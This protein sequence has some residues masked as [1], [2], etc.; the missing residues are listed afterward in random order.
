MPVWI[1]LLLTALYLAGLFWIAWRRDR[2]AAEPGF[3][4]S[5]IVY[6]LAI[7]VYCTSWTYFGAVGTA[8]SSGWDYLP[9]YIGPAIVFAFMPGLVRRIGDIVRREGVTSLSD[10]LSARYGKSQSVATLASLAAVT[11]S[12]PYIALQL[13]SV[14]MSF[15]ALSDSVPMDDSSRPADETVLLTALA[16][17]VFAIL[18]GA[19]QSDKTRQNAGL[20]RVLAFEAL[21]K[22]GALVAVCVLSIGILSGDTVTLTERARDVFEPGSLSARFITITLLSMGAIICLPRQ[23]HVTMIERRNSKD[24]D[25]ARWL[26]PAYMMATSLVV[27]PIALVG[28]S[29]LPASSPADLYVLNLPLSQGDGILALLVF[30]GGFSAAM[31]MVIVSTVAL[32]TMVTN[33]LIVP[34]LLKS[35]RFSS[36]AGDSGARLLIIR[37]AVILILLLLAY[38]Y[39]RTAGSS[40]ALAQIGLLSFAS[41]VQF[42]PALLGGI[43]WKD[44]KRAGAVA[45]LVLGMGAWA[46]TLFLPAL[47]G[48]GRMAAF[49]PEWLD[50]HALFGAGLGDSLTHGVVWSL[51]LNLAGYIIGS[52]RARERLRDRVQAAAFTGKSDKSV[53]LGRTTAIPASQVTPD[54]LRTL[55]ER[56]LDANAVQAAFEQFE[57]ETAEQVDFSAP[58][59]WRLVQRTER[60]LARALGSSSARVVMASAVGGM[61]VTLPDVLSILDS[62]TRAERF[63]R[64]ML[65]SMLENIQQGISVVDQDQRL[66]AWNSAYVDLFDYP[67]DLVQVGRPVADLITYNLDK[68]WIE[69]DPAEQARRRI[70]H[71]R[72]GR[73]HT[74]ER[75]NPDGR[76]L[77]I[78]GNPMPGGGYVTTFTDIT[79]DKRREQALVDANE[80]LEA[81]VRE[82]TSDLEAMAADLHVAREDAEGANASK[83]R[84]LAAASHDL[85]QPLNAARLFLG[86]LIADDS[87]KSD[88]AKLTIAKTDKAIQSADDLLKGLLDISRLDHGHVTAKPV[89]IALAPLL[90]DL[91]D[92][93]A[94]MA[95]KVGLEIRVAPTRLSVY[96]DPDYLTSILRNFISNARRYTQAG[97]VLVGARRRGNKAQIEVWD[98]GPGI[99]KS[100]QALLFEEF[101]RFDDTDN[102]GLRGAGLGLSVVRRLAAIMECDIKVRSEPGRGSVF[103]I[104]VPLAD[105]QPARPAPSPALTRPVAHDLSALRILCVDDEASIRDG[106]ATLLSRWGCTVQTVAKYNDALDAARPGDFDVMIADLQLKDVRTGL[107]LI[108]ASRDYLTDPE[109][110]ALLT[111]R[112]SE[113]VAETARSESIAL[114]RKPV[115]PDDLRVFLTRCAERRAA[116]A[117][118]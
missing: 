101:Q 86:A 79:D 116:Q 11:G 57:I 81:R 85:L 50:P 43:Y 80:T 73:S 42:A 30:L 114:L 27:V 98:T 92:E 53:G 39:Y 36:L 25:S 65:Q 23:F 58:A 5:P 45:G 76:Y 104:L 14:G 8:V 34:A 7:A 54:G 33:D 22:L 112:A 37:R 107:N 10:F 117:A 82:R 103:S 62:Q 48:H 109:N 87:L 40:E 78:T 88:A 84:F 93:A 26:F 97:G 31:G 2:E 35:G 110:V 100:R 20:M 19:R 66:V 52:L 90:E 96:A 74:Y 94:P 70:E 51:G 106:M 83:T 102:L 1:I 3:V 9:I 38:G 18:F 68:G 69:G 29:V 89:Q 55:A 64:H 61:D 63:D 77:R 47:L 113:V 99:S 95:E 56:F 44:G 32:S 16:L 21:L 17:A 13:K 4:Q 24:M 108:Q 72:R 46:Y 71:I 6:A 91:A 75:Q 49:L 28:M 111:A 67:P 118:E 105:R 41:A 15:I 12:L 115:N 59:D 60:M